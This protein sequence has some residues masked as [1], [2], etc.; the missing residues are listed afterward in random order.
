[1]YSFSTTF[2][3]VPVSLSPE[4]PCSSATNW[5]SSNS[6]DPGALIVIDVDTW[7]SGILS[8]S[9]RM[10]SIESIATP[11]LPTSPCAIG[12][13]ESYPIWV[14]RSNAT[15]SPIVPWSISWWYR[16]LDSAAVP[17]PAYWRMVQGRSVYIVGYT[18][19]VNGYSP[20]SPSFSA[21]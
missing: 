18:P 15:D 20:G 7:S 14:G 19:R 5:Y 4:T 16:R 8:N 9:T 2:W 12:A 21:G 6:T 3:I 1:M 10:S 11:T 17:K 13:S